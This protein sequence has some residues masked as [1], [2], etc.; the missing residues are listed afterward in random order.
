MIV[1]KAVII[2]QTRSAL[3]APACNARS[4]IIQFKLVAAYTVK[5]TCPADVQA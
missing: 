5:V 3:I 2:Q 1:Y 4:F